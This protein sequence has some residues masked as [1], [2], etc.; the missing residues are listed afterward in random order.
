MTYGEL[1]VLSSGDLLCPCKKVRKKKSL[2][3]LWVKWIPAVHFVSRVPPVRQLKWPSDFLRDRYP[4]LSNEA[5]DW[6]SVGALWEMNTHP[7][8]VRMAQCVWYQH[9]ELMPPRLHGR[10]DKSENTNQGETLSKWQWEV[11]SAYYSSQD[12]SKT[13]N[14]VP[15][16]EVLLVEHEQHLISHCLFLKFPDVV[17]LLDA[18]NRF[19]CY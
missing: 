14:A 16:N 4:D 1:F 2:D 10:S 7:T 11:W 9:E 8:S 3:F 6:V 17:C 19:Y 5:Q 12:S 18:M 13:L 15:W